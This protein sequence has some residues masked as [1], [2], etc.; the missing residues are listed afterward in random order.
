MNMNMD[1]KTHSRGIKS[2]RIRRIVTQQLTINVR[3]RTYVTSERAVSSGWID[4][5]MDGWTDGWN[6]RNV[7]LAVRCGFVD[8]WEVF[9]AV[10]LFVGQ[11]VGKIVDG[12]KR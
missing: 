9:P 10:C 12:R 4:G 1:P 6:T 8:G 5:W 3:T 7:T 11:F 2:N